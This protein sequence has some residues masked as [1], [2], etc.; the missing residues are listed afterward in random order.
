MESRKLEEALKELEEGLR[1]AQC[2]GAVLTKMQ[3]LTMVTY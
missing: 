3:P 2:I 1:G